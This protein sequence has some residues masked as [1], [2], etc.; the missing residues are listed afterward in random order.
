M[1]FL[2]IKLILKLLMLATFFYF[3][4]SEASDILK[5]DSK[6]FSKNF[7]RSSTLIASIQILRYNAFSLKCDLV[8]FNLSNKATQFL[9]MQIPETYSEK[10]QRFLVSSELLEQQYEI[11]L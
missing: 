3:R 1:V 8:F 2:V 5:L 6:F 7:K 4:S 9:P 10:E 11:N